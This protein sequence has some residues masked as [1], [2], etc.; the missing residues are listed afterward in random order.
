MLSTST[1]TF[2]IRLDV[3]CPSTDGRM[4]SDDRDAKISVLCAKIRD[5][6]SACPDATFILSVITDVE[7]LSQEKVSE[8]FSEYVEA[9]TRE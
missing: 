3:V 5:A 8:L 2:S 9:S 1:N 6:M 7:L 4:D